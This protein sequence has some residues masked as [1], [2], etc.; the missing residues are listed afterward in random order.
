MKL[1]QN[2]GNTKDQPI[3]NIDHPTQ[4][5]LDEDQMSF[6]LAYGSSWELFY[7]DALKFMSLQDKKKT[8]SVSNK[9]S[10]NKQINIQTIESG[11]IDYYD[12]LSMTLIQGYNDDEKLCTIQPPVNQLNDDNFHDVDLDK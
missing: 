9:S 7:N 4:Q 8:D 5:Y 10:T 2:L 6:K 12:D 3:D 11:E 1:L